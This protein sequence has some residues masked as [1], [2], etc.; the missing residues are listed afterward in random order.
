MNERIITDINKQKAIIRFACYAF[1]IIIPYTSTYFALIAN[2]LISFLIVI[3]VGI[4][5]IR[6]VFAS[7]PKLY[8]L[9]LLAP[10]LIFGPP[11]TSVNSSQYWAPMIFFKAILHQGN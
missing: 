11:P 3:L 4:Y 2:S 7:N 1:V 5:F 9:I 8:E 10:F 6:K